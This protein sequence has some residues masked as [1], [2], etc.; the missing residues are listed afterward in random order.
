MDS[1]LRPVIA[2]VGRQNVGK[3][4]LFNKLIKKRKAIVLDLPGVT[5]DRN[6]GICSYR[7]RSF[8]VIDTGG[9]DPDQND[10]SLVRIQAEK[11][12]ALSNR[13]LF[14]MDARAGL[15][16]VD[17]AIYDTLR[18]VAS[19]V[20]LVINKTEGTGIQNLNEFYKLGHIPLYPIS[21]EHNL[22]LTDL[23]DAIYPSLPAPAS[24]ESANPKVLPKIVVMGRPNAGK[25]TLI[26]TLLHEERLVVSDIP[27]TTRDSIDTTVTYKKKKY[28][29]IDT[30]GI[31]KR[32]KVVHGVEQY[33]VARAKEA[34]D[35]ADIALLLVD[36]VAGIT[37]QDVRLIG[38][39]SDA[40]RGFIPLMNKSDL[41]ESDGKARLQNQ[42][43]LLCP[44]LKGETLLYISGKTG[45]GISSI[46][47]RIELVYERFSARVGTS[48][49]NAF[50]ERALETYPPP[51]IRGRRVKIYY[52]TQAATAPPTF[53]FF[54]NTVDIPRH[55]M[56]YLE[57][58]LREAF[59][60]M[61]VPLQIKLRP[62]T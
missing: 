10:T 21:A 42:F 13:I 54:V 14:V 45:T 34:L 53:V 17:E 62:K 12:I 24:N 55:Y 61:G 23:L 29:F 60:L 16:P 27:G 58:R 38:A 3:S 32:G 5:R 15:T 46:F 40:R 31:R 2:L 52:V 7:D 41:L 48:E 4:T 11:A 43:D 26:N 30:A 33:S 50:F 28:L 6:E 49:L 37:D 51:S 20:D 19:R 9:F 59:G 57:N 1:L 44:F 22:G 36:G 25:S 35:R 56:H 8:T 18:P 47:K 39:I